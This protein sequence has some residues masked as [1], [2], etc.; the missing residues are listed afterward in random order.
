MIKLSKPAVSPSLI[1]SLLVMSLVLQGCQSVKKTLGIDRDPPNEYAVTPSAQPLE[2]PPDFSCL[3]TPTPGVERPQDKAARQAQEA[4]FLGSTSNKEP[5][6]AGQKAL[7][8]MSRAPSHQDDVRYMVDR[9]ARMEKQEDKTIVEKLGIKKS[10][11]K[12]DAL[13]PYEE[14]VEHEKQEIP[15]GPNPRVEVMPSPAKQNAN[16][17]DNTLSAPL[18]PLNK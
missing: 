3:P 4:K 6:S 5:L 9:E 8:D 7:L 17:Q 18:P 16:Q 14:A 12:G 13:N 10:K 15:L 11:P 1:V 2:M